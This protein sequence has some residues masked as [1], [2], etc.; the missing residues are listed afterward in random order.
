M[1]AIDGTNAILGRLASRV[2]KKLM[3]G[4]EVILVNAEKI[5]VSGNP[6]SIISNY[7]VRKGMKDKSDPEK[8]PKWP[9]VP[10]LLVRRIIRGMLPRKRAK[11]REA[12]AKL[13]VYTGNPGIE[14]LT[15]IEEAKAEQLEKSTTI[16]NIC[17]MMGWQA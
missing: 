4:N 11:G 14:N 10:N 1:V 12:Y 3:E 8:S 17:K 7:L 16:G 13:K 15:T 2:A 9:K 6:K 5:V